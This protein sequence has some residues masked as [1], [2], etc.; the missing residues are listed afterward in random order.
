MNSTTNGF[1]NTRIRAAS[2]ALGSPIMNRSP[3]PSPQSTM[4]DSFSLSPTLSPSKQKG[5]DPK[6]MKEQ[7]E[8]L[9][10]KNQELEDEKK[11]LKKRYNDLFWKHQE[12]MLLAMNYINT[13]TE[14]EDL[15]KDLK[16]FREQLKDHL[17]NE[18]IKIFPGSKIA[19][20]MEKV[21]V[22][23]KMRVVA[24]LYD[25]A[26][27]E[28]GNMLVDDLCYALVYVFES[29][30]K[31][32]QLLQWVINKEV[33]TCGNSFELFREDSLCSKIIRA[34]FFL[35]GKDYLNIILFSTVMKI[36]GT[37][38]SYEVDPN[39][40]QSPEHRKLS[41]KKL[42]KRVHALVERILKNGDKVP[43]EIRV[44]MYLIKDAV[45]QRFPNAPSN[46]Y[47]G[48]FVFLRFICPALVIP[49]MLGFKQ[50]LSSEG[51]RGLILVA[52]VLQNL[53]NNIQFGEKESFMVEQNEIITHYRELVSS[54]LSQLPLGTEH[55]NGYSSPITIT[56][57]QRVNALNDITHFAKRKIEM[58]EKA[59]GSDPMLMKIITASIQTKQTYAERRKKRP[60]SLT[61]DEIMK[62]SENG[63]LMIEEIEEEMKEDMSMKDV[64]MNLGVSFSQ[65][66]YASSEQK[67]S[68]SID[69]LIQFWSSNINVSKDPVQEE[70]PAAPKRATV[71][72]KPPLAPQKET[73]EAPE[74]DKPAEKEKPNKLT[75]KGLASALFRSAEELSSLQVVRDAIKEVEK[76]KE[77]GSKETPNKENTHPYVAALAAHKS[78]SS[79]LGVVKKDSLEESPE[80][81]QSGINPKELPRRASFMQR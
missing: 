30:G 55:M 57:G 76:E 14:K 27:T 17:E 29:T 38:E 23:P 75:R 28:I 4:R 56:N 43:L 15:P 58:L 34:Y 8:T 60:S 69:K 80:K 47:L 63:T 72:P 50:T 66:E 70:K 49:S 46:I 37:K 41:V 7:L 9:A 67:A 10:K 22:E 78:R 2:V 62:E 18:F 48:G 68:V 52:K 1:N 74:K 79:S 26:K 36:C 51:Q 73:T 64:D 6:S 71:T 54:F 19:H 3:T 42:K 12:M 24:A 81:Q 31:I 35:V 61:L 39:R 59:L 16:D 44:V 45:H 21:V 25:A 77:N 32:L 20:F 40:V 5:E 33:T 13:T 65:V 53:S 11:L